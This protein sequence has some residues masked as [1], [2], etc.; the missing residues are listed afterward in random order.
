ML[1]ANKFT[2]LFFMAD[3]FCRFFDSMMVRYTLNDIGKRT[4]HQ[5]STLLKTEV[6]LIIYCFMIQD[7]IAS[8]ISI[9]I[10]F[11]AFWRDIDQYKGIL[12]VGYADGI[13]RMKSKRNLPEQTI[14]AMVICYVANVLDM[15]Y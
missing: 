5:D 1:T 10:R 7:A 13:I 2:E 6:M 14:Q 9:L 11:F 4:N 8:N 12:A 15:L 3:E